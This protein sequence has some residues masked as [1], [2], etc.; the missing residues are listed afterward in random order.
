MASFRIR[1]D[2]I[3]WLS[4][5]QRTLPGG[6]IFDLYYFCAV[7][8]LAAGRSEELKGA[9]REMVD[10]FVADYKPV[11][12]FILAMLV[13]AE[14]KKG[15]ISLTEEGEVRE[16]FRSLIAGSGENGLTD[17]GMKRLN[18]YANGGY[19]Y[20]AEQWEQRPQSAEEFIQTFS[21][22]VGHAAEAGPF[23]KS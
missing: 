21:T 7:A 18:A 20:L 14:L 2:A 10:Y 13:V 16:V 15:R 5:V 1:E 22:L 8:G 9:S 11:A 23:A 6:T 4:D 19:E 12:S 3:T 17:E